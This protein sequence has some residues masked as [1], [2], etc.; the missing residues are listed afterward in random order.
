MQIKESTWVRYSRYFLIN[1]NRNR[2]D[3]NLAFEL[4]LPKGEKASVLEGISCVITLFV[5]VGQ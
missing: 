5:K 3:G 4:S 2:E 1:T